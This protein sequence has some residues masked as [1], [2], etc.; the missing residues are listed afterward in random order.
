ME[1]MRFWNRLGISQ[2]IGISLGAMM[3]LLSGVAGVAWSNLT[4]IDGAAGTVESKIEATLAAGDLKESLLTS[5]TLIS[6]YTLTEADGELVAAR[7]EMDHLKTRVD[8]LSAAS[9]IGT[10]RIS[11]ITA[12]YAAYETATQQLLAAIGTRRSS[13]EDFTQAATAIA[14]TTTAVVT[15][16]FREQRTDVLPAGTKLN[17]LPQA[18]TV[19]VSRYLATRNP[20]YAATAK[21][22]VGSLTEA[23]A[24]LGAAAAESKRIQKFLKVL[25][26]QVSDY[27]Q[28]IETL[29]AAT[30]KSSRTQA[31][32]KTAADR[33]LTQ[34]GE[35]NRLNVGAQSQAVETMYASVSQSR[36]TIGILSLAALAV[37]GLAWKVL[38]RTIV[39]TLLRLERVM[40]QLSQGDLAVEVPGRQRTDE[41]GVMAQAVQVFKDNLRHIEVLQRQQ[42]NEMNLKTRR[43]AAANQ[44]IQDFSG[45]MSG[46]LHTLSEASS[47][48]HARAESMCDTTSEATQRTAAVAEATRHAAA[49]VQLV[50]EAG[51]ALTRTIQDISGQVSEAASIARGAVSDAEKTNMVMQGLA[52]S[53][54]R[55]NDVVKLIRN[56]AGQT[57][58]LALNATIEAARAGEA[59][60]GF[61]VVASEVKNLSNQTARATEE[62][63]G[64]I[65]AIQREANGALG[66]IGTIVEVIGRIDGIT[67]TIAAAVENQS[68][69][70]LEIARNVRSATDETQRVSS[71]IIT[72][73]D[74]ITLTQR[75]AEEVLGSSKSLSEKAEGMR[76]E[77]ESFL[78][79]IKDAGERRQYQRLNV[80]VPAT[81]YVDGTP[82][83]C[84]LRDISLGGAT[85]DRTVSRPIGSQLQVEIEGIEQPLI[86]RIARLSNYLHVQ[87]PLD[88]K[89]A[90]TISE[91]MTKH[92]R[93]GAKA[94][95]PQPPA[96]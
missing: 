26:P 48:M 42:Q 20:A 10:G 96:A 79:V 71:T 14:T 81:L 59:G 66:A 86:V 36:M 7:K 46:V 44:L 75:S 47:E 76:T 58:L 41:I 74:A 95:Q 24:A 33:L 55:I 13:S 6:A 49:N 22:L 57:N 3:F 53:A 30:D 18:G 11:E 60:K 80:I 89:T 21:Q 19:A 4:A 50:A 1:I 56:I 61:A 94:S 70:T 82:L 45:S 34:I 28:A 5:E 92:E 38:E 37:A 72:V 73:N 87:F 35:L 90:A 9:S 32:R 65:A 85:F 31:E 2:K 52:A 51:D 43:Q 62:I 69:A 84:M 88:E 12:S 67:S 78:A 83:K 63:T 17:D 27:S 15:A 91:L 8:A 16:L 54:Q 77:V 68:A 25:T 39:A 40:R 64:Q 93:L 29:I 23:I